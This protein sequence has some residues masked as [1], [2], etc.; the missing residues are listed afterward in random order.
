MQRVVSTKAESL[1]EAIHDVEEK[2]YNSEIVLDADDLK[3][4]TIEAAHPQPD[5]ELDYDI[6]GLF[7]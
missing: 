2:Y 4:T 5:K 7:L 3:E 1:Q 6:Q